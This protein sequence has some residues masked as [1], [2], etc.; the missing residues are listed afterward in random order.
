[1]GVRRR[2]LIVFLPT[3]LDAQA[4]LTLVAPAQDACF[5]RAGRPRWRP[6]S[7][8]GGRS[9]IAARNCFAGRTSGVR[10]PA[11][12]PA[13]AGGG[14]VREGEE[15]VVADRCGA[16]A[17]ALTPH[18]GGAGGQV[19]W[20]AV[21]TLAQALVERVV[22][23]RRARMIVRMVRRV[24]GDEIQEQRFTVRDPRSARRS[25]ESSSGGPSSTRCQDR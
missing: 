9:L 5:P 3:S 2:T 4:D 10:A 6:A 24:A 1:M 20:A 14:G 8:A 15:V 21:G 18:P 22:T 11:G 19:N 13:A 16:F 25:V 17:A 7:P 12:E 23:G